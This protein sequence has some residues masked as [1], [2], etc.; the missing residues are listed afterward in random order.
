MRID[1]ETKTLTSRMF[2]GQKRK[3]MCLTGDDSWRSKM[4]GAA[5]GPTEKRRASGI[6]TSGPGG[7]A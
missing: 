7:M 6:W 4:P 3:G 2:C 1:C 5:I